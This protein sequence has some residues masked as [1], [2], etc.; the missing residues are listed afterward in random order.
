MKKKYEVISGVYTITNLI[1]NKIYVGK[2]KNIRMRNQSHFC[3]LRKNKHGNQ[4]LQSAYNKYGEKNF[5]FEILEEHFEEFM[6]SF[7]CYWVNMLNTMNDKYGYN[8]RHVNHENSGK[9]SKE[10]SEK[11]SNSLKER[12]KTLINPNSKK[13][14]CLKTGKI[15]NTIKEVSLIVG[16]PEKTFAIH[17]KNG[18]NLDYKLLNYKGNLKKLRKNK[19]KV[20]HIP[21][22]LEFESMTEAAIYF[23]IKPKLLAQ[24]LRTNTLCKDFKYLSDRYD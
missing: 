17:L 23:N 3:S 19:R 22:K 7:E 12:Y 8:I 13:V 9:L 5:V 24:R 1:D 6:A 14:I 2:A 21:T 4:H 20:L 10:S 15:F 18:R 11:L 16:I